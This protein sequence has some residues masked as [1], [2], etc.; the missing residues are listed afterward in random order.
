MLPKII[1]AHVHMTRSV[2]QE[3][4][5][6]PRADYPDE[7]RWANE[8]RVGA[9]LDGGPLEAL[10][11]VN[12]MVLPDMF[13]QRRRRNPEMPEHELWDELRSRARD[14]NSWI[15][16]LHR[17]EPR[18]V[19]FVC[20]DIGV[21]RD[22]A[23]LLEELERCIGLG[24]KGVKMHPGLGRYFPADS[25]MLPLYARLEEAG[26]P[27]L[28]DTG[29]LR[30]GPGDAVYGM[31]DHF[32]PVFE[33]FG[34]LRFI[35]A[36]MPSAYWDQRLGIAREHPQVLFDTA[37]GFS[38]EHFAARDGRR[39]CAL[40]DAARIVREIG[41]ER[42]LFGS[43]APGADQ[44]PQIHQLLRSGLGEGELEQVLAGNARGLLGLG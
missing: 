8:E 38:E 37:G 4:A 1:D 31:P 18:V 17:R 3:R 16:D 12:Y 28:S 7:W 6:F 40:E 22:S 14:F 23:T 35:M 5:V 36:H 9:Q 25:R 21:W 33:R 34:G 2:A 43:D 19:P 41:V 13:E 26:L 42:V 32:R 44:R 39:A 20:C 24:A 27:I 30:G 15:L 29:S 11:A 10:V